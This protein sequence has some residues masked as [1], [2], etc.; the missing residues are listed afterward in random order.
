[1]LDEAPVVGF[2]KRDVV[3][4]KTREPFSFSS[5]YDIQ[6]KYSMTLPKISISMRGQLRQSS[7]ICSTDI[8]VMNM[9]RSLRLGL[10]A[11]QFRQDIHNER[12]EPKLRTDSAEHQIDLQ[13]NQR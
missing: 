3:I 5:H 12:G 11:D 4:N 6:M 10:W 2:N 8:M 9:I 7:L 13:E 1:M